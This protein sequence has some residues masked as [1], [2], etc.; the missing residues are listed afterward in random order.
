MQIISAFFWQKK[1]KTF[2]LPFI[3]ADFTSK[4]STVGIF[5]AV[6]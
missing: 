3:V 2:F 1:I 4:L 5:D 6:L